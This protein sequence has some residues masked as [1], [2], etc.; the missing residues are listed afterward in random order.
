MNRQQ[1]VGQRLFPQCLEDYFNGAGSER[2][3]WSSERV[4]N[5]AASAC[6]VTSDVTT[7]F[8]CTAEGKKDLHQTSSKK[9]AQEEEEE[10]GLVPDWMDQ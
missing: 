2:K 4:K 7:S 5:R 8:A 6:T 3:P 10:D 9:E 1:T